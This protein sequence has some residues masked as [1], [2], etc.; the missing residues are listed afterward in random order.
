MRVRWQ[1]G[2]VRVGLVGGAREDRAPVHPPGA[3]KQD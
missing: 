2:L 1:V 3:R